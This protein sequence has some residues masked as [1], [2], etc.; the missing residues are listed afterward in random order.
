MSKNH[1]HDNIYSILGKLEALKPTPEEKRFAL[2]K[3]IQ[4][5]VEA[6]GSILT[7]VDAVQDK[8]AEAFAESK[9]EEKAVSQAQQKFMG[10]VHAAQKGA[11]PASPEVAKVAKDMKKKDA[12]DFASTKHKGLPQHVAEETCNECGLTFEGCECD[13]DMNEGIV[14]VS[15][16]HLTLPTKRIV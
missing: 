11:K 6:Q 2:V 9:I 16:T 7:G 8:L 1:P 13:H 15:Y 12:K 5:S 3:E 10:M 4:E 14:A